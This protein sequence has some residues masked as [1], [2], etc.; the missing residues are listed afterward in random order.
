MGLVSHSGDDGVGR[1]T[2]VFGTHLLTHH[3]GLACKSIVPGKLAETL[4][5]AVENVVRACLRKEEEEKYEAEA[6]EP[7]QLPNRPSPAVCLNCKAAYK[8]T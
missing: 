1:W 4:G 3:I 8:R 6:G 7:H 5:A 2:Y